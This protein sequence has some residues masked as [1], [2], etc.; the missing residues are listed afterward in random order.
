MAPGPPGGRPLVRS[1]GGRGEGERGGWGGWNTFRWCGESGE[2]GGEE[3][4]GGKE[5]WRAGGVSGDADR[6]CG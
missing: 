2:E 3:G 4:E 1:L 5:R 6:L